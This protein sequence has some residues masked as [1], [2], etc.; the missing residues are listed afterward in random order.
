[1]EINMNVDVAEEPVL[2]NEP[3]QSVLADEPTNPVGFSSREYDDFEYRPIPMTA[4]IGLIM[5]VC[6][7]IGVFVWLVLPLTVVALVL[8]LIA[9]V[10][11]LR[12]RGSYGGAGLALSGV[13]LSA[14]ILLAGIGL[15]VQ[16]YK[17]EVPDGFRR[18]SF[19]QDISKPGLVTENNFQR[20]PDSIQDMNGEDIFVKG[21]IYQTKRMRNLNSFL[22]VKDNQDCCFGANPAVHDRIGVILPQGEMIDYVSGRVGISG[23]FRI[24]PNFNS[25]DNLS[26]LYIVDG[27]SFHQRV[28]DF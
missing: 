10:S 7:I 18:I 11:I 24:N 21:Y 23:T 26:P 14:V 13:V 20:P 5:A 3:D 2:T 27:A 17:T 25:A 8:S 12:S 22:F 28:S 1:M 9:Y 4:L 16:L 15:Q 19:I 6:S